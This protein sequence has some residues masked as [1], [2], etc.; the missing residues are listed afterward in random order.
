MD[1]VYPMGAMLKGDNYE[2]F[3]YADNSNRMVSALVA[4]GTSISGEALGY[5]FTVTCQSTGVYFINTVAA[6]APMAARLLL[7]KRPLGR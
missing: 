2:S 1:D 6:G 3:V 5:P 4:R 7:A